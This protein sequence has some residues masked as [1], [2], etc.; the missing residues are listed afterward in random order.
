MAY[1]KE[2]GG[3]LRLLRGVFPFSF[4]RSF[5]ET[6]PEGSHGGG[7]HLNRAHAIIDDLIFRGDTLARVRLLRGSV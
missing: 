6:F 4:L 5:R 2:R 3:L 7:L 1:G